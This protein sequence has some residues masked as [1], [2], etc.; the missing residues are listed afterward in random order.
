LVDD[1]VAAAAALAIPIMSGKLAAQFKARREGR[2]T[3]SFAF[4]SS[5]S[6]ARRHSA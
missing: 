1:F 2:E 5:V 3:T 4:V 6:P